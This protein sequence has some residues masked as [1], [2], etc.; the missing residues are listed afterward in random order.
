MYCKHPQPCYPPVIKLKHAVLEDHPY[1]GFSCED[2]H[3]VVASDAVGHSP[4]FNP[5]PWRGGSV[6]KAVR[7]GACDAHVLRPWV[8]QLNLGI[9]S[10]INGIYGDIRDIMTLWESLRFITKNH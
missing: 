5:I 1:E 2:L 9:C 6:M 3:L 7:F 8:A 10:R 4:G